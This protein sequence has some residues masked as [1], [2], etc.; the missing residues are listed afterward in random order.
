MRICFMLSGCGTLSAFL[1]NAIS[2]WYVPAQAVL[3]VIGPGRPKHVPAA[4][5]GSAVQSSCAQ[6]PLVRT[7]DRDQASRE[8]LQARLF[9]Q[10]NVDMLVL[11]GYMRV[12][13]PDLVR[14]FRRDRILNLHP[15]LL[16][17]FPG[18]DPQAQ[19]IAAGVKVAGVTVHFVTEEVDRGPIIAQSAIG[20]LESDTVESL[21]RRLHRL[22]YGVYLDALRAVCEGRVLL[23]L[24]SVV[25]VASPQR[26]KIEPSEKAFRAQLMNEHPGGHG[27][28]TR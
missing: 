4:A 11:D 12:L 16:P 2:S 17:A 13:S 6:T 27:R 23:D 15:G 20:V 28:G 25:H 3:A 8:L 22:S 7:L 21:S 24:S 14:V 26:E 18:K 9:Q 1:I 19:A 5:V 10:Y